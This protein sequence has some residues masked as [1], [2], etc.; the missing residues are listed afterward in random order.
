MKIVVLLG[1]DSPER[2][3]S[4]V[5]GRGIAQALRRR[6]HEVIEID[7]ALPVDSQDIGE[8]VHITDRPASM[9]NK[10]P[11]EKV[12]EWAT[13]ETVLSSDHVFIAL[14]G[15]IGEDGTVQAVLEMVGVPYTGSGVLASALSMNKDRA[16]ALFREAGVQTAP[17]ILL[18]NSQLE[19]DA[20]IEK[21]LDELELPLVVKP[22]NQ[23]SSVGFSFVDRAEKLEPALKLAF[24]Y[25]E[26]V[27]VEKYIPGREITVAV[28]ADTALPVVE[29]VPQGG[30][31]DYR[32]KYTKGT[33]EYIVPAPLE[34]GVEEKVKDAGLR[35]FH[36]LSCRDYARVDLRLTDSGE[37][38]C[39]EVNTLPGMTELSLVPMAA[40]EA[41]IE[42]DELVERIAMM[43]FSRSGKRRR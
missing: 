31:Y 13:S 28:L 10:L 30:F 35:A 14:H 39:L 29:I 33:T 11:P 22:N 6:R 9:E 18:R 36:A 40:R 5:T 38:Y 15:G 8:E 24:G 32:R 12:L 34:K 37:P 16:K 2:D 27:I 43:A 17:H 26:E 3:V 4:L 25:S 41:G 19:L 21:V 1:G 23:G 42:F 7:P 20:T